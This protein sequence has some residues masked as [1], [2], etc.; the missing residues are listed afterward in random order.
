MIHASHFGRGWLTQQCQDD[1]D[2]RQITRQR[3]K[4]SHCQERCK[5]HCYT[6]RNHYSPCVQSEGLLRSQKHLTVVSALTPCCLIFETKQNP[7]FFKIW[8][9][10]LLYAKYG[11]WDISEI[12]ASRLQSAATRGL[13]RKLLSKSGQTN[14]QFCTITSFEVTGRWF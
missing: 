5:R 10:H 12:S 13:I 7:P 4:I 6:S 14:F 3:R 8:P 11:K 1:T 2:W 9:I